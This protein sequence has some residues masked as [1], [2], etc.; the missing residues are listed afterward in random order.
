[1]KGTIEPMLAIIVADSKK[2]RTERVASIVSA[3][4]PEEIIMFDDTVLNIADLEQYLYPSLFS[5]SMPLI[6]SRF[7]LDTKEKDFTPLLVKKIIASPTI[8]VFEELALSK[9]FLTMMQKQGAI[10]YSDTVARK[11]A[12][13]TE[14][15]FGVTSLLTLSNKKD[16]WIAYQKAIAQYPIEAILGMLYWKVRELMM[17]ENNTVGTYHVLYTRMLEAHAAAWQQGVPLE[18]AIEKVL[19]V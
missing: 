8:F 12:A 6:H 16:R 2:F 14:T 7:I 3:H 17:K 19:L 5:I 11:A 1:M 10:V 15:I 18:L 9:P 13:G 4:V